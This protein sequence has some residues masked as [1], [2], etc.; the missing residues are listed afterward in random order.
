MIKK[1][2]I[3]TKH[4][5]GLAIVPRKIES[6]DFADAVRTSWMKRRCFGLRRLPHLAEHLAGTGKVEFTVP[7]LL[8]QRRKHVMS[9]VNIGI[10]RRE[11][12]VKTLGDETLRRKVI[13]FIKCYLTDNVEYARVTFECRRMQHQLIHHRRD[14]MESSLR[15]FQRHPPH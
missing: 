9:A 6:G 5:V 3:A 14:S 10:H 2:S 1:N 11:T 8:I 15:I 13:A 7:P 12:V 4:P